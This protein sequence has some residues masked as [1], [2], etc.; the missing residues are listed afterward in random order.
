MLC[1]CGSGN[2]YKK[3]CSIYH[4]G[5]LPPTAL[6]LMKSRYCA[7]AVGDSSYIIKTTHPDNPDNPDYTTDVKSWEVSILR[8][9][10]ET[11]FLHLE[12]ID[13]IDG[14]TEAFVTFNAQL[15]SG[16]LK[17]KSRFLKRHGQW[18]YVDGEFYCNAI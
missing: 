17:E 5:A 2:K 4:K 16:N 14:E 6:L 15:S 8:F 12:I 10:K 1:P 18:L 11:H 7:Y 3:C 13:F 9:T